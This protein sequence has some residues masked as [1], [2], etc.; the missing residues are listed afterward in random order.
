M[1]LSLRFVSGAVLFASLALG[2]SVAPAPE[3]QQ[4][5]QSKLL[6]PKALFKA[7]A[8]AATTKATGITEWR[9][10]RGKADF[11]LTGYGDD[12]SAVGGTC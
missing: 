9:V 10:F 4:S 5:S 8:S 3:Q 7:K 12:G 6:A 1:R 11:V 2:C